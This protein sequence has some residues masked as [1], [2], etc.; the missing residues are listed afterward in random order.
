MKDGELLLVVG[1]F[2]FLLLIMM[3]RQQQQQAANPWAQL[4]AGAG[5]IL[6]SIL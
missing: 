3:Q 4:G 6:G 5:A 2:G 1:L